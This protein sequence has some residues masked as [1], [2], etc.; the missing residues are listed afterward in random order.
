MNRIYAT[1]LLVSLTI[2]QIAAY[3]A[4]GQHPDYNAR[5]EYIPLD[6][7]PRLSESLNGAWNFKLDGPAEEFFKSSFD[8]SG[9]DKITVPGNWETQWFIEPS[10][11][12]PTKAE[13]L[14]RRQFR[15]PADWQ[16]K[17]IFVRFEGVAFGFEFWI[18]GQ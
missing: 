11:R 12:A 9:W 18:D 15:V 7:D 10:Y 1:M 5:I 17:E 3:T 16:G 4:G 6:N 14:Y 2:V 8:D 13:G